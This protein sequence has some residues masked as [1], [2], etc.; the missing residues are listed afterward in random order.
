[1]VSGVLPFLELILLAGEISSG[2][3][4]INDCTAKTRGQK[5]S[6]LDPPQAAK[7]LI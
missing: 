1:L 5:W 7:S 3:G 6:K 2:M 4:V